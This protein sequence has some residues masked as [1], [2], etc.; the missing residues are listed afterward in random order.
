MLYVG[1]MTKKHPIGYTTD[2]TTRPTCSVPGCKK[3]AVNA[4]TRKGFYYWRRAWWIKEVY[5]DADGVWCCSRHH[6]R[7]IADMN[8]AESAAH[9]TAQRKGFARPAD[10]RNDTH[11]YRYVLNQISHCQN[12]DGRLGFKCPCDPNLLEPGMLQADHIDGNHDNN[13]RINLQVICVCCHVRKTVLFKDILHWEDKPQEIVDLIHKV[14]WENVK[15]LKSM[16]IPIDGKP[17]FA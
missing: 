13:M 17:V 14:T 9:V 7:N 3:P 5:T 16:N 2:I 4:S 15:D 10:M 8:G 6:S 1:G 12:A 11:S